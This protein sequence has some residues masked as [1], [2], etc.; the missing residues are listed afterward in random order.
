V[1]WRGVTATYG[2]REHAAMKQLRAAGAS[3]KEL[4][5]VHY[6]VGLFDATLDEREQPLIVTTERETNLAA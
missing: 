6:I 2:P 3:A 1:T 4:A 5:I